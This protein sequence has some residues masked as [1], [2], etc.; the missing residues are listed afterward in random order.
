MPTSQSRMML[1]YYHLGLARQQDI[2]LLTQDPDSEDI[3]SIVESAAEPFPID[4]NLTPTRIDVLID[5]DHE[6]DWL[7]YKE[8]WASREKLHWA[9]LARDLAGMANGDG[10]WIIVGLQEQKPGGPGP[11]YVRRGIGSELAALFE[12]TKIWDKISGFVEEPLNLKAAA[13]VLKDGKTYGVVFVW[14][15]LAEPIVMARNAGDEHDTLFSS[16][17]VFV[18][19]ASSTVRANQADMRRLMKGYAEREAQRLVREL[20]PEKLL[21][22]TFNAMPPD[23]DYLTEDPAATAGKIRQLVRMGRVDVIGVSAKDGLSSLAALAQGPTVESPF[24]EALG[25]YM[26][27]ILVAATLA[28]SYSRRALFDELVSALVQ[29]YNLIGRRFG[30]STEYSPS[31]A[32]ANAWLS[33]MAVVYALGGALVATRKFDHIPALVDQHPD[34]GAAYWRSRSWLRHGLTMAARAQVLDRPSLIPLGIEVAVKE[35]ELQLIM[36]E[37]DQAIE[38]ACQFDF[39]ANVRIWVLTKDAREPYPNFGLYYNHRTDPIIEDLVAGGESCKA[40]PESTSHRDIADAI[41]LLNQLASQEFFRFG[42]W[43]SGL[44]NSVRDFIEQHQPK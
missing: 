5:R 27:G 12:V 24:E 22:G 43:D 20:F 3:S 28:I 31:G 21:T 29:T 4:G 36:Y 41:A 26:R 25:H 42:G 6:E 44:P 40:L 35:P 7:D 14:R 1:D 33:I 13:L 10:G 2:G 23:L 11:R 38:A 30:G 37:E 34:W 19:R 8:T 9:K 39:L 16:G 32:A 18:R 17:D 15:R